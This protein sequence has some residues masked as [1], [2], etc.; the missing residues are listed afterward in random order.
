[1]SIVELTWYRRFRSHQLSEYERMLR[2]WTPSF[3]REHRHGSRRNCQ[4]SP[5]CN[6]F[7]SKTGSLWQHSS[8]ALLTCSFPPEHSASPTRNPP[9]EKQKGEFN[10]RRLRNNIE[11][12]C[13]YW[14]KPALLVA[15][16]N[17]VQVQDPLAI[18]PSI[19]SLPT[20]LQLSPEAFQNGSNLPQLNLAKNP[21]QRV[22]YKK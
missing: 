3:Q 8:P 19:F 21:T 20:F 17:V 10:W 4:W 22:N 1:M 11:E 14:Q 15:V 7:L 6:V 5:R 12:R 18:M 16:I 13:S 9:P 2:T